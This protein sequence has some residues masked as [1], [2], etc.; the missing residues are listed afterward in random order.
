[1]PTEI[2]RALLEIHYDGL[3]EDYLRR[4]KPENH[5]EATAQA[6]Q[7]R[8]PW[9]ASTSSQPAARTSSSSTNCS[10]SIRS[11]NVKSRGKWC[12]TTWWSSTRADQGEGPLYAEAT[13]RRPLLGHGVR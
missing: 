8:S 11:R 3:A 10:C 5:M 12:R 7:A 6:T 13:A 2:P 9:R 1:M 4:L